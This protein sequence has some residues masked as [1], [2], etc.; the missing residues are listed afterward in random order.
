M[1]E[2][3]NNNRKKKKEFCINKIFFHYLFDESP[4][5][6]QN[7]SVDVYLL[8]PVVKS[9]N[10]MIFFKNS[11]RQETVYKFH[12]FEVHSSNIFLIF[13]PFLC[14]SRVRWPM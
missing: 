3:K 9:Q 2:K 13:L 10:K 11:F 5:I 14:T 4:E 7:R 1:Q 8:M 12:S 6:S